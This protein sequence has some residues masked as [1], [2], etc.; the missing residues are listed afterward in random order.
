[1][2]NAVTVKST[3]RTSAQ[4]ED[5]VLREGETTRLLF[6]SL[7]VANPT[8]PK[9]CVK[10]CFIFQKKKSSG[11]WIDYKVSD[12]TSLKDAEGVKLE[13]HS[14]EVYNL[15]TQLNSRYSIFD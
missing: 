1:M 12:L 15:L 4:T 11:N 13:L 5:I 10:G 3:S 7:L 6:R 9:H 14:A 2:N 8:E